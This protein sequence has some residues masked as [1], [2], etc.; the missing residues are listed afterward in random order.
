MEWLLG[1]KPL[2]VRRLEPVQATTVERLGDKLLEVRL[3]NK[4]DLLL[5]L[6]FQLKSDPRLM[7]VR[8]LQFAALVLELRQL[9]EQRGKQFLGAVVYLDKTTSS[10]GPEELLTIP[11]VSSY[12]SRIGGEADSGSPDNL[13]GGFWTLEGGPWARKACLSAPDRRHPP[14]LGE[15]PPCCAVAARSPNVSAAATDRPRRSAASP[16]FLRPFT[17]EDTRARGAQFCDGLRTELGR[18]PNASTGTSDGAE[19]ARQEGR[20][21]GARAD[22]LRVLRRRFRDVSEALER[23]NQAIS[24]LETLKQLLEEAA[25]ASSLDAFAGFI[26]PTS[27]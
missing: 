10:G 22:L 15:P 17:G 19:E 9:D 13:A 8:M 12:R 11:G 7:G 14:A 18:K 16:R 26:P 21:E 5:H 20:E 3:E 4:P 6:E 1:E 24:D 27:G 23:R 25:V 2:Q